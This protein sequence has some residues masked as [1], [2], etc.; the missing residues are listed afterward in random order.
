MIEG[1]GRGAPQSQRAG[2]IPTLGVVIV[3]L[4]GPL[5]F[6]E[7]KKVVGD[8]EWVISIYDK[9][10]CTVP[11]KLNLPKGLVTLTDLKRALAAVNRIYT[12]LGENVS[13]PESN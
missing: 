1:S 10:N 4:P 6:R 2:E 5:L 7:R 11:Y 3:S 12:G 8:R 9:E 13:T